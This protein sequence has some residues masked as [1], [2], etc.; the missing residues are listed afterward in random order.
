M[1]NKLSK[2]SLGVWALLVLNNSYAIEFESENWKGSFNSTLTVGGGKRL[3]DPSCSLIGTAPCPSDPSANPEYY[4]WGSADNGNLNY[5]KGDWFSLY[6]KGSHELLLKHDSGLKFF[7]RGVWRN[8]IG[9]NKTAN[10]ETPLSDEAQNQIVR[11]A[12]ML[13]YWVSKD[14]T[15]NDRGARVRLGN[16][17]ISWGESLYYTGGISTNAFDIQKLLMPGTQMKEAFLP[18]KSVSVSGAFSDNLNAEAYYQFEWRRN[19]MPPVGSY[20]STNDLYDVGRLDANAPYGYGKPT[21]VTPKDGG[22][23]GVSLKWS[24]ENTQVNFGFFAANYHDKNPVAISE[25]GI[26]TQWVFP[27]DRQMYG[28]TSSFPIGNW[29]IGTELSYRPN[30]AVTLSP[31]STDPSLALT[32]L[33]LSGCAQYKDM[34]KYQASVTALLQLQKSE[35]SLVLN[36]LGADTAFLTIEAGYVHYPGMVNET[37]KNADGSYQVA[38]AGY[39]L[40]LDPNF[41]MTRVGTSDSWGYTIDFNWTYDGKL[42]PG[43]QLTPGI[44]YT[45]SVKGDTPNAMAQFLEGT[46][47]INLYLLLNQNPTKW[48]YGVNYTTWFGG[49]NDDV[50]RQYYKDRSFF[51]FF[52]SYTF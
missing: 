47:S 33:S 27:R 40:G 17:V 38:Q 8:D 3:D 5:K 4:Q 52:G 22:E 28:V 13:D 35:H 30:D 7:A 48:Q 45:H 31:C 9:A 34:E 41:N 25:S 6:L 46:K 37:I 18:T 21:D 23:Y 32:S 26:T 11:N 29:A 12:E 44:T 51:G 42:I 24:P 14:F 36:A 2:I 39:L 50:T 20:F 49:N 1:K 10:P 15:I 43:W 19:R 16:Q